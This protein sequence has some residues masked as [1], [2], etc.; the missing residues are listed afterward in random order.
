MSCGGGGNPAAPAP[1]PL[2][3]P[4]AA[5]PRPGPSG[6]ASCMSASTAPSTSGCVAALMNAS[7]AR[8]S[9][10]RSAAGNTHRA[11]GH[12]HAL[13]RG[14]F[15]ARARRRMY[16]GGWHTCERS[17]TVTN[18]RAVQSSLRCHRRLLR[19]SRRPLH[20]QQA[21]AAHLGR[22]RLA[23]YR[24]AERHPSL[25]PHFA[26]PQARRRR[27]RAPRRPGT[28]RCPAWPQARPHRHRPHCRCIPAQAPRPPL[29]AP[30]L[31]HRRDDGLPPGSSTGLCQH[32]ESSSAS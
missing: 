27:R 14:L 16:S 25:R 17:A 10:M 18:S 2:L 26:P 28:P 8:A 12:A 13:H 9:P 19:T 15:E 20:V 23:R 5:K 1:A 4:A 3:G 21:L 29:R 30:C 24:G 31:S 11:C 6:S 7:A 32:E 22:C